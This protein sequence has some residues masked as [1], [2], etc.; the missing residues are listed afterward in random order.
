MKITMRRRHVVRPSDYE[1]LELT[2]TVEVDLESEM[3]ADFREM[4]DTEIG[5]ALGLAM[6]DLLDK[7]VDRTLRLDGEHINDTHLWSFYNIEEK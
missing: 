4:T 5:E 1:S 2:A 3:D 6:D 7:E